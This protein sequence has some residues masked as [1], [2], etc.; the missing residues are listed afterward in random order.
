MRF[1]LRMSTVLIIGMTYNMVVQAEHGYWLVMNAFLL[2]RPMYEDSKYRM[3]TRFIGTAAGC[4]I[5]VFILPFHTVSQHFMFAGLMAVC[6]YTAVPGTWIHALCVTCFALS[7]TTLAI[8]E[9]TAL[10]LR[11]LYVICAVLLVL[12]INRFFSCK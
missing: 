1:A 4:L 5:L 2:L 6:M 9:Q 8:G 10:I 11:F 12:V 7:M 3:K